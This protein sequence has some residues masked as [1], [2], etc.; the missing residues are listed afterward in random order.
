[1]TVETM[2]TVTITEA[3]KVGAWAFWN[4]AEC[5]YVRWDQTDEAREWRAGYIAAAEAHRAE[6]TN[7]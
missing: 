3:H 7:A 4:D 6:Q 1:M 2:N 5:P